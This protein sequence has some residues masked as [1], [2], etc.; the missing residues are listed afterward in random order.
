MTY[1]LYH[2]G[3]LGQRWGIRRFQNKDGSL[4][5]AGRKRKVQETSNQTLSKRDAQRIN[6]VFSTM[7]DDDKRKLNVRGDKIIANEWE[8]RDVVFSLISKHEKTPV[9]F[10]YMQGPQYISD[11]SANIVIGT[12]PKYRKQGLSSNAVEKGIEWFNNNPSLSRL[13]WRAFVDN[14]DSIRLARLHGFT[15]DE[16]YSS[17]N[18]LVFTME[19]D[20]KST[21]RA[22]KLANKKYKSLLKSALRE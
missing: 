14:P 19:K 7:S 2:H 5:L 10:L 17:V 3:I 11:T 18:D 21:R 12:D 20:A 22:K 6:Q 9:S 15:I 16:R 13:E 1:E 8:R 4:T